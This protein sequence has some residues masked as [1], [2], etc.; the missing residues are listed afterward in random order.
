MV[1]I[2]GS[3]AQK[4]IKDLIF[5]YFGQLRDPGRVHVSSE[6]GNRLKLSILEP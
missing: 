1:T 6:F 2:W 3:C 4:S 5:S